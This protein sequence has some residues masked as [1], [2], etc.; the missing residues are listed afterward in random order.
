MVPIQIFREK[1]QF[2]W[3]KK[4]FLMIRQFFKKLF[5]HLQLNFN[6]YRLSQKIVKS[7]KLKISTT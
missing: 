4:T 6:K 3:W 5:V 7:F 1:T 2:F